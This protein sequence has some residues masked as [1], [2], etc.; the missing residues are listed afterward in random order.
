MVTKERLTVGDF[1]DFLKRLLI[2]ASGSIYLV[3]DR[4]PVHRSN[5]K[6]SSRRT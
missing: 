4:H 1:I 3:L 6:M 2:G 5:K